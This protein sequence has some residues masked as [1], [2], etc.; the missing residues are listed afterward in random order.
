[1]AIA[2]YD[3]ALLIVDPYNDFISEGSK[4]HE[5]TTQAAEA[6]GFYPNMRQLLPAI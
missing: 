5:A 3:T 2:T 6:V 1:M 4:L